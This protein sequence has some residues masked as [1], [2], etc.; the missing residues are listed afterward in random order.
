VK[1][2]G[3]GYSATDIA[4]TRGVMLDLTR[5]TGIISADKR[6]GLVTV[7]AGTTLREL[8]REL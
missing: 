3:A 2:V 7:A 5:L 4:I 6:S 8:S 1:A